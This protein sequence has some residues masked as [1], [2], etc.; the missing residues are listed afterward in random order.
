MKKNT[1]CKKCQ[2]RGWIN[3]DTNKVK[4]QTVIM[5]CEKCGEKIE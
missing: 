3:I 1:L 2:L 5:N 4:V